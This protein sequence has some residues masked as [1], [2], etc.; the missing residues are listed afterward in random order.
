M[1]EVIPNKLSEIFFENYSKTMHIISKNKTVAHLMRQKS[2]VIPKILIMP[3]YWGYVTILTVYVTKRKLNRY[4]RLAMKSIIKIH[5][6]RSGKCE[7]S[8]EMSLISERKKWT[9]KKGTAKRAQHG[10]LDLQ[11]S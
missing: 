5:K 1:E 3:N 8:G 6:E 9:T 10:D 11:I 2:G 4:L 7:M